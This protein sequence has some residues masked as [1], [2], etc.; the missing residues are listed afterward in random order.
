MNE[1]HI[2]IVFLVILVILIVVLLYKRQSKENMVSGGPHGAYHATSL[3]PQTYVLY[4]QWPTWR[5]L[6]SPPLIVNVPQK[7]Q[8]MGC[9]PV[10]VK[11]ADGFAPSAIVIGN[12]T[13]PVTQTGDGYLWLKSQQNTGNEMIMLYDTYMKS[14]GLTPPLN[15]PA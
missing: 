5:T 3:G 10:T 11:S 2:V 15:F 12:Q 8:S 13:F 7:V 9:S 4:Q 14:A 1:K 6:Q